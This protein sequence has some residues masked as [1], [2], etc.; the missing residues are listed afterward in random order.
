VNFVPS[1]ASDWRAERVDIS[2]Y[3]GSE[4]VVKFQVISGYGNDIYL[5]DIN[6]YGSTSSIHSIEKVEPLIYPNPAADRITVQCPA[7]FSSVQFLMTDLLGRE[8]LRSESSYRTFT[9][10]VSGID[11]G[12]YNVTIIGDGR[13]VSTSKVLLQR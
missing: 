5:D 13:R 7:V 8:V 4:V 3:I 9:L 11:S 1:Q 12:C 6:I 10:D 2:N